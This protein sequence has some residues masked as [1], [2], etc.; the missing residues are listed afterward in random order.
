M[1]KVPL[2]TA[3]INTLQTK[4][5]QMTDPELLAEAAAA[6]SD[7]IGWVD[8]HILITSGQ[9]TWLESIDKLF[10]DL[11]AVKTAIALR[12][13]LPLVVIL[14]SST[15]APGKWFMDKDEL[16]PVWKGAGLIE[17]T[18]HLEFE[19]SYNP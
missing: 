8:S 15:P 12:N 6:H 14:P 2:S 16:T 4:L 17:A 5:Y 10:I 11:L 13:R 7:F 18:G 9:L 1:S 3:G 19:I